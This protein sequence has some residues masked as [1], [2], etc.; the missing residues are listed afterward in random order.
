MFSMVGSVGVF[1]E[2]AKK[3]FS[4][5]RPSPS[6]TVNSIMG[7][8]ASTK[9]QQ[10]VSRKPKRVVGLPN[11]CY[12]S[13]TTYG[14]CLYLFGMSKAH[15]RGTFPDSL[16]EIAVNLYLEGRLGK[17]VDV[18]ASA[19]FDVKKFV[20]KMK[21]KREKEVTERKKKL[22]KEATEMREKAKKRRLIRKMLQPNVDTGVNT[23][24]HKSSSTVGNL[25]KLISK[26]VGIPEG[27]FVSPHLNMML[28]R[29]AETMPEDVV[30]SVLKQRLARARTLPEAIKAVEGAY[31]EALKKSTPQRS[32]GNLG[33]EPPDA[34]KAS[35]KSIGGS[36]YQ[37][38]YQ[39]MLLKAMSESRP[40]SA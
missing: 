21:E 14:W 3:V 17:K 2:L 7:G 37:S 24:P 25:L 29:L 5:R 20:E 33:P 15:P 39:K 16:K 1:E 4:F 13:D 28:A 8:S 30:V 34:I 23:S 35:L 19:G 6:L 11:V 10:P 12:V 40:S 32:V 38:K 27:A 18:L 26:E 9:V 22:E 31:K 36:G